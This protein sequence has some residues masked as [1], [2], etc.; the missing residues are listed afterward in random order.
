MI[1]C[2]SSAWNNKKHV[3]ST[4]SLVS[5]LKKCLLIHQEPKSDS[6]RYFQLV[7]LLVCHVMVSHNSIITILKC[8][9]YNGKVTVQYQ[10]KLKTIDLRQAQQVRV[11]KWHYSLDFNTFMLDFV[12]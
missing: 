7:L 2:L 8:T 11:E 9:V 6:P 3:Y 5:F 1:E 12:F 10:K 4:I